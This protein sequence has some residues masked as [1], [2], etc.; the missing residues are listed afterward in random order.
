MEE[1]F[2]PKAPG[3][4][5]GVK[6]LA[7]Q[8]KR[9]LKEASD[10]LSQHDAYTLHKNYKLKFK[11]RK[12]Y[13]HGIG[14][15]MQCDL[16]DLSNISRYNDNYRYLLCCIDVFSRYATVLPLKTKGGKEL[17]AAFAKIIANN[18]FNLL[19]T[20]RGTEFYNSSV[21][22]LLR[23]SN[24]KHYSSHNYDIKAALV[25]R[26]NRTIKTKMYKYFTHNNTLRYIDALQDLVDSYNNTWHR[27]I[28][29]TP[30]EVNSHN[31]VRLHRQQYSIKKPKLKYK[32]N[33]GDTVRLLHTRKIFQKGYLQNWTNKI[34]TIESRHPTD[35]TSN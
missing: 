22:Q 25:E 1:Y 6:S 23:D 7:Q 24:V 9:T 15:L 34:F 16:A 32:F 26:F 11:R 30:S 31:E 13:S 5:G 20:D 33:I 8:S 21:Q 18:K 27:A 29:M 4:F 17:T 12:T 3:S 35:P 28:K 2:N 10:W 19:Q 14:D